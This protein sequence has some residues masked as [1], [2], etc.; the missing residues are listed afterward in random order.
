[1]SRWQPEVSAFQ[2]D[3][4]NVSLIAAALDPRFRKLK[5]LSP[6]DALKLQVKE[7]SVVLDLKREQRSQLQ[8]AAVGQ[9]ASESPPPKKRSVLDT[10]LGT[11]SEEEDNNDQGENQDE[12]GDNETVR[13]E[14]LLYFGEKTYPKGQ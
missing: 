11:D 14:L 6:E 10:L 3:G 8:Q 5:F 2:E 13:K 4:K 7:Q 12:D 9:D 1:M